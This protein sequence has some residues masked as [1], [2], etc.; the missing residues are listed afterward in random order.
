MAEPETFRT[1]LVPESQPLLPW[2]LVSVFAHVFGVGTFW[3]A[4]AMISV[5]SALVPLCSTREPPIRD[6]IEVSVVS[7]PKSASNVPDR[8]SR[9]ARAEGVQAPNPDEPP[10][11]ATSDLKFNS[12]EIDPKT[13]NTDKSRQQM[14]D[15]LEREQM[16]EE[17]MDAPEGTEDRNQTDPNGSDDPALASLGVGSRGDPEFQR[18]VAQVQQLLMQHFKPLGAVTEGHPDLKCMVK[19]TVD[20]E[21]GSVDGYEVSES[22]GVVPFDQAAERAVQQIPALPLPPEKYR[23]LL[24]GGVAFRFTPP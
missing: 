24:G 1:G 22:S 21:D 20:P 12:P 15:A 19:L 17:M 6:A 11:I 3:G 8:A 7:M 16:L 4:T 18:W 9:V 5:L 2:V 10:P 14:L 13:G 23:P